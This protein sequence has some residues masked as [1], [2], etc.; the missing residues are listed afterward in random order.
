MKLKEGAVM[1][2]HLLSHGISVEKNSIHDC[3][4]L[5]SSEYVGSPFIINL[6]ENNL[7]DWKK[8][9]ILKHSLKEGK[10]RSPKA[11]NGCRALTDERNFENDEDYISHINLNHWNICNSRCIYCNKDFNGGDKYFNVLPLMKTLVEGGYLKNCGEVTFQG[12]EPTV[13]PEFEQLLELFI[14]ESV[15]IRIHSSGIKFSPAVEKGL[16]QGLVSIIISPD[17]A[18]Q[19]TYEK[20]KRVKCFDKVWTNL[21]KYANVQVQDDKVKSKFIVIPGVNDSIFEIDEFIKKSID[22]GIKNVIWEVEGRYAGLYDYDVPNV[23]MLIDYAQYRAKSE[24]LKDE[25]YDGAIYA[26]KQHERAEKFEIDGFKEKYSE[27][28]WQ[29]RARNLSYL[30]FS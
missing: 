19:K 23:C 8:L 17:S 5:R 29:Y 16:Q 25:F 13:L 24:G 10:M 1:D 6:D 15:N 20:I 28:Q 26:M 18:V 21:K 7:V 11:C 22:C 30:D 2:C 14:S 3:C 27:I 4:L 12:G 9:F